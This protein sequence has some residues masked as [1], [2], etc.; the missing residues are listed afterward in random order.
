MAAAPTSSRHTFPSATPFAAPAAGDQG[1]S[2]HLSGVVP[3]RGWSR[4]RKV[5]PLTLRRERRQ[6]L[7]MTLESGAPTKVGIPTVGEWTSKV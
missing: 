3:L 1:T 5:L 2:P 7:M 6:A 4:L